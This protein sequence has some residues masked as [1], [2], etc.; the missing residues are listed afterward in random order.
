MDLNGET[1]PGGEIPLVLPDEFPVN[2]TTENI[3]DNIRTNY[4]RG[5]PLLTQQEL[6][7]ERPLL[8]VCGG[9]SLKDYLPQLKT[10][11]KDADVMA[12]NGTYK[13]LL[14]EGIEP[15]YFILVDSREGNW[16]YVRRPNSFTKHILASQV[17]PRV[18]E[19]LD[20]YDVELVNIGTP[21]TIETIQAIN[22]NEQFLGSPLGHAG[23]HAIYIGAA[24][25][26]RRQ[27]LFGYDCSYKDYHHAFAQPL[28]DGQDSIVVAY[29]GFQF[30]TTAGL[31][32]LASGFTK[33]I[34]KVVSACG[35]ELE[36]CADGLLPF[37]LQNQED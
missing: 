12:V 18:Y 6:Q 24:L 7:T 31:A 30:R 2:N 33:A 36:M 25:G 26:Y 22:P 32:Q 1:Q 13:F 19:A 9:P 14:D 10:L 37:I 11:A 17:H 23:V 21:K 27:V 15:K 29:K 28:N 34:Q 35:L 8:I 3:V 16:E 5:L 20:G 4:S